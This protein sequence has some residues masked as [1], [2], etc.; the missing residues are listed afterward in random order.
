[1]NLGGSVTTKT[2]FGLNNHYLLKEYSVPQRQDR[3]PVHRITVLVRRYEQKATEIDQW[4][5]YTFSRMASEG[6]I[7]SSAIS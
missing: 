3:V 6:K 1:V 4:P 2:L 5:I 7:I